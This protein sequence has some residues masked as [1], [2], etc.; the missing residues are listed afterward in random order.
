M[1]SL[2]LKFSVAALIAAG[3]IG[4]SAGAEKSAATTTP[5]PEASK[6]AD[7]KGSTSVTT[8]TTTTA[9]AADKIGVAECDEYLTKYENCIKDKV[10]ASV[11]STFETS[12]ASARNAY[13]TAAASPQAKGTLAATCAAALDQTKK[14]LASYNCTW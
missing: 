11:R 5:S 8:T 9:S 2:L 12:M 10:P 7:T 3:M 6:A 1:K 14:S 4:C 13:K